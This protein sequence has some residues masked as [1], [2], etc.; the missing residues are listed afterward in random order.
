MFAKRFEA[1]YE[2]F[3]QIDFNRTQEYLN[4]AEKFIFIIED[5]LKNTPEND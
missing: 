3:F 4:S 2:D 1:D 5:I